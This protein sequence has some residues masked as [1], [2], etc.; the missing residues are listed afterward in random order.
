V[1]S[2]I[3]KKEI[4]NGAKGRNHENKDKWENGYK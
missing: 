4:N 3:K 2:F 1:T